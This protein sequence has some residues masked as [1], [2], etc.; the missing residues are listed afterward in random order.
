VVL[1]IYPS[2]EDEKHQ[3]VF[4]RMLMFSGLQQALTQWYQVAQSICPGF[5][6]ASKR[7]HS[8]PSTPVL[9]IMEAG[10]THVLRLEQL[11]FIV[12][13]QLQWSTGDIPGHP[14][15]HN[16][17]IFLHL[18]PFLY[19]LLYHPFCTPALSQIITDDTFS[20]LSSDLL[21]PYP[22][23]VFLVLLPW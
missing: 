18:L 6:L 17:C 14:Q 5:F 19:P 10:L 2:R 16:S 4:R 13:L 8:T 3:K 23:L 1:H 12:L 11:C 9:L 15:I 22:H 7:K 21:R 20:P